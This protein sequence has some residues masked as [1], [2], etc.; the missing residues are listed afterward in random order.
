MSEP[1]R[2]IQGLYPRDRGL[3]SLAWIHWIFGCGCICGPG[4]ITPRRMRWNI[5]AYTSSFSL[6]RKISS[7]IFDNDAV[8]RAAK[9]DMSN[10]GHALPDAYQIR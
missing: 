7:A 8:G 9:V 3:L 1:L 4:S 5:L 10:S 2:K 6:C